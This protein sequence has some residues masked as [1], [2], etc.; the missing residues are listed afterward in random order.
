MLAIGGGDRVRERIPRRPH[1]RPPARA[2]RAA[3]SR[4]RQR[5]R[6]R[7]VR[8]RRRPTAA[9]DGRSRV[10]FVGRVIPDKGADVLLRAVA[11]LG[12][13]RPRG[14]DRRQPRVRR[15]R[16][17]QRPTSAAARACRRAAARRSASRRSCPCARCPR[18]CARPMSSS[19]RRDGPTPAPLTVGEALATG[20]PVIASRIGGIPEAVGDAGVLVPPDDPAALAGALRELIDDRA[21][22]AA[23]GPRPGRARRRA[24]GP[25]RGGSSTP[26]STRSDARVCRSGRLS[27]AACG[28]SRRASRP[29]GRPSRARRRP[30]RPGSGSSRGRSDATAAGNADAG[31]SRMRGSAASRNPATGVETTG[32]PTAAY[33]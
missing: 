3:G 15:R 10:M 32:R 22:R 13:R 20:L 12:R 23:L 29:R 19:C 16:P 25:G 2:A 7:T 9:R 6:H 24:I 18:S 1:P 11:Q 14:H 8:A 21:R 33:S 17:A 5:R 4:R 26:S 30:R 28:R 27:A 31:A